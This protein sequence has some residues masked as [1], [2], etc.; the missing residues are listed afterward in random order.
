MQGTVGCTLMMYCEGSLMFF[1]GR[2]ACGC[3]VC[4]EADCYVVA[5]VLLCLLPGQVRSLRFG[6]LDGSGGAG[7]ACPGY[8][9]DLRIAC[10]RSSADMSWGVS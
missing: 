7:V 3:C 10:S 9:H 8:Q 6:S 5:N 2:V 4:L 1:V